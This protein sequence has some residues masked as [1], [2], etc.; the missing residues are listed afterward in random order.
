MAQQNSY[1][2]NLKFDPNL[3][4]SFKAKYLSNVRLVILLVLFLLV[5]G[6]SSFLRLPKR[7]NPEIKIPIVSVTTVMPGAGPKDMESLVTVPLEDAINSVP[8]KT[9][10]DS[11]S[12]DS[13][14]NITI[15]FTSG[16]DPEK[17]KQDV[18][19][20]IDKVNNL[21]TDATDPS[22]NTFDFENQ[23]VW[24]FALKTKAD[25]AT[26]SR[27][28]TS[29]QDKLRTST[30][31]DHVDVSGIDTQ[32]FQIL[33][34]PET[35]ATYG[36][37]PMQ[38]SQAI[39][40]SL[41]SYPGGFA[42]TTDSSFPIGIDAESTSVGDIRNTSI[43][44]SGEVVKLGDIADVSERTAPNEKEALYADRDFTPEKVV[45]FSVFKTRT[46][47]IDEAANDAKKIV[48]QEVKSYSGDFQVVN[49]QDSAGEVDKQFNDLTSNFAETILLVFV[50][51]LVFLGVRQALIVSITIPLTFLS[52]FSV[53]YFAGLS[54][55]FLS[56]FSLLLALGLLVDD[57]IVIITGITSYYK[58]GKF[59]PQEAGLLV[60]RDF[61]VPIWSTTITT[62]WAF[63]PLL[64]ATGII[65]EFIK[66]IPI[67][68]AATLYSSTA[69]AV[70]ITL[71]LMMITLKLKMPRRVKILLQALGI[72]LLIFLITPF[73]KNNPFT[74]LIIIFYLAFI[75][76]TYKIR[77]RIADA[78]KAKIRPNNRKKIGA[79]FSQFL[80]KGLIDLEVIGERY[81]RLITRI[82][83]KKSSRRKVIIA[84]A[85]F[86]LFAYFLVPAGFVVNEFFP[87]SKANILYV[88]EELPAGTKIEETNRE[89]KLLAND[90]RK[91]AGTNYVTTQ[92][93]SGIDA[94]GQSVNSGNNILQVTLNLPDPEK[95]KISSIDL[96]QKLRDKYKTYT[97]G[98]ISVVEESGGPPAGADLQIQISGDD[99]QKLDSYADKVMGYLKKQPG[100]FNVSKSIKP[101]VSKITFI[102]DQEKIS[103]NNLT[104][105]TIGFSLRSYASGVTVDTVKFNN[106]T[107][108]ED[109][110]IRTGEENP[111]PEELGSINITN[112]QGQQI[113]LSD[114]GHFE[115]KTNPTQITRHNNKRTISV[116]AGVQ[117]GYSVTGINSKLE[118][119]ANSSLNLDE[120]YSWTT[121]GVN[122][123]NNK[124]VQSILQA[125]ILA[126]IL[127][128]GTM[129]IQFSSYRQAVLVML[130]IPIAISGVFIIFALTGTPLSFPALIGVLSLFGI[131]V[132]HAMVLVDR[133][134]LNRKAG[135]PF[136]NAISDAAA[137]RLEPIFL[138]SFTT[139]VGL[140]PITLSNPLWRGLGGAIVAGLSFSIFIM[141]FFVPTV[142]YMWFNQEKSK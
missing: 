7:L 81:K 111:K 19:S 58:T 72:I 45:S 80:N 85:S 33:L 3:L 23:P 8:N 129:V 110:V 93:G 55:N 92:V 142:Y 60:W 78:I 115:L 25:P 18:K 52:A 49:I 103:E 117:K 16:T 41:K 32:E 2:S 36:V 14:S 34:K 112:S 122:D 77:Y 132:T 135:L 131:V 109:I 13:V 95:Q 87:K 124:S 61:I 48:N 139:I 82:L 31:V 100:V 28:A 50:T 20:A 40:A 15:Q 27:V 128:F 35:L 54:I 121:G 63:I 66:T 101:G 1:L 75:F 51:F 37:N 5:V 26:L 39:K 65:G 91:T 88:V 98:T 97:K 107:K 86:T 4:K 89:A 47:N 108:S 140:V 127:I 125:M 38:V 11:V 9:D 76:L 119:Y 96:A 90:L 10:I 21:P 114:L 116:S 94:S 42:D 12:S 118:K 113:P 83:E 44:L 46:S 67:V 68:V 43:N 29:L 126:G 137:A 22:I 17:A 70:L 138:G 69:I 130:V 99:L 24:T 62:V 53:M 73:I 57:S 134:N 74:P 102:P 59:T 120:G 84:I 64:I 71:P 104:I 106:A 133:I 79:F 123:E 56:L 141:L 136:T 6:I 105:D 30:K